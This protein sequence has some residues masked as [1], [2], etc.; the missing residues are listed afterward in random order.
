MERE[1]ILSF[2]KA[3]K[4]EFHKRFNITKIAL[5]GSYAKGL[6]HAQS[7]IDIVVDMEHKNYFK[8]IE[9]ENFIHSKLNKKVDE[10]LC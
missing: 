1:E 9:F 6:N 8:L 2:L 3:H 7:D 10:K 5:F 4:E